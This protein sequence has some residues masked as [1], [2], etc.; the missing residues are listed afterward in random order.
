[1]RTGI[2]GG[3][4]NPFHSGHRAALEAFVSEMKL[5]R[6]FVIPTA[7]P[8][9]KKAEETVPDE[10]RL[11]IAKLSTDDVAKAEVSDFE[12]KRGG[13]SYTYLTLAA[14]KEKYPDDE[15]FLYVGSDMLLTLD[16]WKNPEKIFSA[17]TI[18]AFSRTGDDLSALSAKKEF[19]EKK[20][21][22]KILLG[23]ALPTVVSSTEIR[24]KAANGEDFSE[25]IVPKAK[26]LALS[27]Y[28]LPT[29][30]EIIN[31]LGK[32]LKPRRFEHTLG[33]EKEITELAKIYGCDVKTASVAAL[34]H[35]VTKNMPDEWHLSYLKEHGIPSDGL[36]PALYHSATG[37]IFAKEEFGI[38]NPGI[39]S[40][41]RFHTTAKP[42]MTLLEK[43]LYVADFTEPTRNY[44]D[45]EH[46]R[47]LAREDIDE[48]VAQ[49]LEWNIKNLESRG[50]SVA[51]PTLDAA[52]YYK[53]RT[54]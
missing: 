53:R 34:L 40:A 23:K 28:R 47:R 36:S 43:L 51:S 10:I 52:E 20:Y 19:L 22:A 9:H 1:M 14:F 42:D 29:R 26:L 6:V 41:I 32:Y 4:F 24:K 15:L 38:H 3:S 27:A 37:S 31:K 39:L 8:P 2:F 54:E 33:V 49:G 48:A 45:V 16:E 21:G 18:A 35:D 5:D 25:F 13:K 11:E 17:A 46:Y 12:I 30:D 7:V 50:L 44:S